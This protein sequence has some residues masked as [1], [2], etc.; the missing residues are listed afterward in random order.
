LAAAQRVQAMGG[1]PDGRDLGIFRVKAPIGGKITERNVWRGQHIE[2][3]HTVFR[4]ADLSRVWIEL[5]VFERQIAAVRRGNE[6]DVFPAGAGGKVVAGVV[7]HVGDV[8]DVET[9]TASV[10][11]VVDHPAF[12]L[13][14]GQSVRARIHLSARPDPT[15]VVPQSSVSNVDG[16]LTVFVYHPPD[17]I[18]PRTVRVGGRD[19]EYVE[20]LSGLRAG[21][22]VATSGV[23][24]LRSTV[25]RQ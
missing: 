15:L 3:T 12:I 9:R 5:A 4:V 22:H 19:D 18:E 16:V 8:I 1:M 20:I 10:R 17:G 14:P 24:H 11:V 21:E 25:F 2:P 13:R 6:V 7:D 23:S